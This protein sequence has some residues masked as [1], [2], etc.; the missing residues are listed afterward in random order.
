MIS[1]SENSIW[2]VSFDIG[3][4]NFAFC[5]EEYNTDS[6]YT[7]N[8]IKNKYNLDGTP[9]EEFSTELDKLYKSGKIILLV[10][11]DLSGGKKCETKLDPEVYFTMYK[12][13]D[14]YKCYWDLCNFFIVEEQMSF[15]KKQNKNACKLGQHCQSYFMFVYGKF[16]PVIEFP[17]YHK[18]QV[19][20][21]PK[22]QKTTKTGKITY[23]A[24]IKKERKDWAIIKAKQILQL[25][26]DSENLQHFEKKRRKKGVKKMKLDDISDCL[27][28]NSSFIFL[29]YVEEKI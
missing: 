10:N 18:T 4:K 6:L 12:H 23:K 28:H 13:L 3:I 5:L 24:M 19:L 11:K 21:A 27:L 2:V 26:N 22:T 9:T 1:K 20:G 17:A 14:D 29:A 7:I 25:R 16:K 15:G 8:N